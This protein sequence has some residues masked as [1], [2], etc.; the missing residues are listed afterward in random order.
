MSVAATAKRRWT[1]AIHLVP[2][3]ATDTAHTIIEPGQNTM[4]GELETSLKD[5]G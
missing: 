1:A 4:E 3:W 2:Q 5:V